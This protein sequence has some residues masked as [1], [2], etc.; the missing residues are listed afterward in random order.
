MQVGGL[1]RKPLSVSVP[2]FARRCGKKTRSLLNAKS[3]ASEETQAIRG[4]GVGAV[5]TSRPAGRHDVTSGQMGFGPKIT[6]PGWSI[7]QKMQN[8]SLGSLTRVDI[9]VALL[10]SAANAVV[11]SDREG[12][13]VL[14]NGGAERIFGF[15]EQEALGKSLDIIIPPPLRARHWDGYKETVRTGASRYGAGDMLAVPGLH[16]DGHRI[17]VEFTISMLI[18]ADGQVAGM[19]AVMA[20]VTKRFEQMKLLRKQLAGQAATS[21]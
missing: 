5:L 3:R 20:D 6:L 12:T 14:W 13:I 9:A 21:P 11:A 4:D 15:T 16:K 7:G 8:P 1:T 10:E 19:V 17:S 18:D 2:P